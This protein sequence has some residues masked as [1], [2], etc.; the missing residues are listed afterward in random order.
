MFALWYGEHALMKSP[1]G[2]IF[3]IA[4]LAELAV[5]VVLAILAIV[6]KILTFV[7]KCVRFLV[8]CV[9]GVVL[10]LAVLCNVPCDALDR[11]IGKHFTR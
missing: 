8:G 1:G 3:L 9:L 4:A 7:Y 10:L 5:V 6:W 2:V 11:W